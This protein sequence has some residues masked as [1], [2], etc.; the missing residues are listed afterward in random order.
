NGQG[1]EATSHDP[2]RDPLDRFTPGF[3]QIVMEPPKQGHPGRNL[4]QAVKAEADQGNGTGKESGNERNQSFSTVVGDSEVLQGAA[5][6]DKSV[7]IC[8][9]DCHLD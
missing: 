9:G 1:D 7:A 5:T 6:L 4:D 2:Q 3:V 8:G